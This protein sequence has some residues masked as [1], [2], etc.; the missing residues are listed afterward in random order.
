[1]LIID[2]LLTELDVL[3]VDSTVLTSFGATEGAASVNLAAKRRLVVDDWLRGALERAGLPA[4]RHTVRRAPD[5]A[6][7]YTAGVYTDLT[8]ALADRTL[9]DVDM[10]TVIA[11]AVGDA[12]YIRSRQPFRALWLTLF[13]AVNTTSACVSSPTYWDG[14]RWAA[15]SSLVDNTAIPSSTTLS[16]GGRISWQLP[17]NWQKRPLSTEEDWGFWMRFQ[18]SKV[19][20]AGTTVTHAL[21]IRTSRLTQPCV[22]RVLSVLYSESW[23]AQ[24]GEWR[25]KAYAYARQADD[26]LSWALSQVADEFVLT[27][28]DEAPP[29]DPSSS[30]Q[31]RQSLFT[32]ERG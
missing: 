29:T 14:G 8:A 23:G 30:L 12:L 7:G 22:L 19:V 24:R 25:E 21:P 27:D 9:D 11:S 16:G 18:L 2:D 26:T 32:M 17:T 20:S 3:A 4:E 15:F 13:D 28:E 31:Y 10:S 5:F 1:M 6:F